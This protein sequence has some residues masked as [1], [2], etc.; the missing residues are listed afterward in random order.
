MNTC[1]KS[2]LQPGCPPRSR[3]VG[4]QGCGQAMPVLVAYYSRGLLAGGSRPWSPRLRM[5]G[6][7][8]DKIS[9][10]LFLFLTSSERRQCGGI[11][12]LAFLS[13]ALQSLPMPMGRSSAVRPALGLARGLMTGSR[14]KGDGVCQVV[15][16]AGEQAPEKG[17]LPHGHGHRTADNTGDH[18]E[19]TQ[20]NRRRP[21][22]QGPGRASRKHRPKADETMGR[23]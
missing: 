22:S 15:R 17:S 2:W 20:T 18:S 21:G 12:P 23:G 19:G 10:A 3:S 13:L 16:T 14:A 6:R 4:I 8:S 11:P 9:L 5:E 7:P 1:R